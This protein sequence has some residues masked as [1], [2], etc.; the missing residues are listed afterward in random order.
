M[1]VDLHCRCLWRLFVAAR[2]NGFLHPDGM[3][4]LYTWRHPLGHPFGNLA[5]ISESST[6]SVLTVV[7]LTGSVLQ[8]L[9]HSTVRSISAGCFLIS[10]WKEDSKTYQYHR[11]SDLYIEYSASVIKDLADYRKQ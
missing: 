4:F 11:K 1:S 5:N 7:P 2:N 6:S 3:L 10:W 8:Q 9:I